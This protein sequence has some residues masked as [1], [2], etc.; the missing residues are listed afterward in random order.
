[1][2]FYFVF[3]LDPLLLLL[4]GRLVINYL[5]VS[6]EDEGSAEAT[7]GFIHARQA[8]SHRAADLALCLDEVLYIGEKHDHV[9]RHISEPSI[10]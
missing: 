6:G 7:Q 3:C 2:V 4:L 1:M 10:S 8:L 9:Q 5:C